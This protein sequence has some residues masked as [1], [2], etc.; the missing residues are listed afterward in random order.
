VSL[1]TWLGAIG[2]DREDPVAGKD[3]EEA[4]DLANHPAKIKC[5]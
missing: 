3:A 4:G 5:Q 1:T 2:I